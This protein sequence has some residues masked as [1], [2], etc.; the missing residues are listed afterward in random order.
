MN[1]KD[2][3]YLIF[4]PM[5]GGGLAGYLALSLCGCNY[6]LVRYPLSYLYIR[7]KICVKFNKKSKTKN[8]T[9]LFITIYVDGAF[10]WN[11]FV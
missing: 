5:G 9:E 6:P 1:C 4:N 2:G 11:V 3:A 7:L 8:P 10:F